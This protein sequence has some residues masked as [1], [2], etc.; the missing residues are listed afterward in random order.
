MNAFCPNKNNKQVM[1]EFNKLVDT[2]GEDLAYYYWNANGGY[3]LDRSRDGDLSR[4]YSEVMFATNGDE[5]AA[6][7]AAADEIDLLEQEGVTTEDIES[8]KLFGLNQEDIM[9]DSATI[10]AVTSMAEV[11]GVE[12]REVNF[13]RDDVLAAAN[14]LEKTIDITANAEDRVK[15]WNKLPEE[16]AH[17]WYRLLSY[18]TDLKHDLWEAA[19]KSEKYKQL[20]DEQYAD[21]QNDAAFVEEAIGQLIAEAMHNLENKNAKNFFDK[22][23]NKVKQII[24]KYI[25]HRNDPFYEAARRILN[26]DVSDLLDIT[27]V[28]PN[29]NNA[30]KPVV[31][32]VENVKFLK[33]VVNTLLKSKKKIEELTQTFKQY[34]NTNLKAHTVDASSIE[35]DKEVPA[36]LNS[37]NIILKKFRKNIPI[38]IV[39]T[40]QMIPGAKKLELRVY[41]RAIE[42]LR[43][44]SDKYAGKAFV[45]TEDFLTV[46]NHV[47]ENDYLLSFKDVLQRWWY[48]GMAETFV[49]WDQ[50]FTRNR[51]I[52]I[53]LN[54]TGIEGET[55]SGLQPHVTTQGPYAFGSIVYFKDKD[56]NT[57]AL[58]HEIQSDHV[59]LFKQMMN[60]VFPDPVRMKILDDNRASQEI[61]QAIASAL[62]IAS[63][64]DETGELVWSKTTVK[65]FKESLKTFVESYQQGV[66]DSK[67]L[68]DVKTTISRLKFK[69]QHYS[70]LAHAYKTIDAIFEANG[71]NQRF[72]DDLIEEGATRTWIPQVG[73][74][75]ITDKNG[76]PLSIKQFRSRLAFKR[77]KIMRKIDQ[78]DIADAERKLLRSYKNRSMLEYSKN[79]LKLSDSQLQTVINLI[80]QLEEAKYDYVQ[81][82]G[83]VE[84][85]PNLE[86][87]QDYF[88]PL[89]HHLIQTIIAEHG[90]D[91]K[92]FF[93]GYAMT[94]NL[95]RNAKTAKIYAN[96]V[97]VQRGLT[98]KIGLMYGAIKNLKG[99]KIQHVDGIEGMKPYIDNDGVAHQMDGLLLDLSNYEYDTPM[100]YSMKPKQDQQ[101]NVMDSPEIQDEMA[102]SIE[103]EFEMDVNSYPQEQDAFVV[104]KLKQAK[105]QDPDCDVTAVVQN[106]KHQFAEMKQKQ[107]MTDTAQRLAKIYG[108]ERTVDENGNVRYIS[109]RKDKDGK[110]DLVVEFLNYI[111]DDAAGF[112]DLNSKSTA[113][114]HVIGISLNNGD[115]ST[116][117]HELAHH[118]VRMFW[119]SKVIQMALRAVDKPGMTDEEREE[120]LVDF[121][122]AKTEDSQFESSLESQSIWQKF[123]SQFSYM[124]A[125]NF[126]IVNN[127]ARKQLLSNAA[128]AFM[129]NEQQQVMEAENRLFYMADQRMYKSSRQQKISRARKLSR[130]KS[131]NIDYHI[132]GTDATHVAI[133]KIIRGSVSRNKSYRRSEAEQP[134]ILVEMQLAEDE[135]R[136]YVD[137]VNKYREQ[138]AKSLNKTVDKLSRDERDQLVANQDEIDANVK[139]IRNFIKRARTE[140]LDLVNKLQSI[141]SNHYM[142]YLR[143]EEID[144]QTNQTVFNYWTEDHKGEPG[145]EEVPL[146]F[147]EIAQIME[148]IIG[149][150]F[151]TIKQLASAVSSVQFKYIYGQDIYEEFAK[152]FMSLQ[153]GERIGIRSIV[154]DIKTVMGDIIQNRLRMKIQE[155]VQQRTDL[156]LMQ[157]QR[158][159]Y[160]MN[161]WLEDQNI[162]GDCAWYE[163]L[164]GM[165]SNSKSPIIRF[166]QDV[167]D[168]MHDKIHEDVTKKGDE[169]VKLRNKAMKALRISKLS[170]FNFEKIVMERDDDGFTGNFSSRVNRG[171][172]NSRKDKFV[173]ELLFSGKNN[174]ED[175]VR[176]AIG[177]PDYEL[178]FDENGEVVFPDVCE[179]IRKEYLHK[180]NKWVGKNAIRE[181]TTEYYDA[182]IDIISQKTSNALR[183][184]DQRIN[185]LVEAAK[186]DGN[187]RGD[188]F[189]T[190]KREELQRLYEEKAQLANPYDRYGRKKTGDDLQ[191]AEEL[192]EWHAFTSDK[193][194]YTLNEEAFNESKLYSSDEQ[195]F[196]KEN[197]YKEINPEIWDEVSRIYPRTSSQKLKKLLDERRRL[198]SR[199]KNRGYTRPNIDI[200]WDKNTKDIRPEFKEFWENL[201]R[202]DR[203]ISIL[204]AKEN[205]GL[206]KN[207]IIA[208]KHKY[209]KILASVDITT[210]YNGKKEKWVTLISDQ[211]KERLTAQ[212]PTDPDLR[213]KI[214]QEIFDLLYYKNEVTG[215]LEY[216]SIF[217][218]SA[219]ILS[220]P[221]SRKVKIGNREVDAF[222]NTPMQA[223]S[224]IDVLNSD[225]RYVDQRFDR[226]SGHFVQPITIDTKNQITGEPYKI[227]QGDPDY[228][229]YTFIEKIDEVDDKNSKH[230]DEKLIPLKEYYTALYNTMKDAYEA[231]PFTG[232]YDGRLAQR[233]GSSQQM[234]YRDVMR[235]QYFKT[236]DWE[237]TQKNAFVRAI[238]SGID[239]MLTPLREWK[240]FQPL[241][242]V[243][244]AVSYHFA[245]KWGLP[246]ESDE[247]INMDFETRP[248]G[249]RS[250]NIPIRYI[251][252]LDNPRMISSDILG[253]VMKFYQMSVNYTEKANHLPLFNTFLEKFKSNESHNERQ[254]N[255]L[256][257]MISRQFY[258]RTKTMDFDP[259]NPRV[260]VS[261]IGKWMLKIIPGLRALTQTGLLALG[262]VAGIVSYLDPL[263]QSWIDAFSGKYI[264]IDD[265]VAG[266]IKML[267]D[268]PNAI[269]SIGSSKAYGFVPAGMRYMGLHRTG[270]SNFDK[271]NRSQISRVFNLNLLMSPFSLGE[272]TVD[273]KAFAST[274]HS[275]R[276]YNGKFYTKRQFIEEMENTG[277]MTGFKAKQYFDTVMQKHTLF[278]AYEISKDSDN[279]GEFVRADNEYG[280]AVDDKLESIVKKRMRNRATNYNYIVPG[281]ERTALQSHILASFLVVM[282]TFMLVGYQ[283]RWKSGHDFQLDNDDLINEAEQKERSREISIEN[284]A[285]KGMYNFQTGEIENAIHGGFFA[286]V[287]HPSRWMRYLKY[288]FFNIRNMGFVHS[289]YERKF[290]DKR[291]QLNISDEDLFGFNRTLTEILVVGILSTL[292]I[293]FH[294][295]LDDD[296]KN[297]YWLMLLDLI[298][299]RIAIERMTFLNFDTPV[300]LINSITPSKTDFD[301]KFKL[302]DLLQDFHAA[303]TQHKWDVDNWEKVK[304]GAYDK[305]PKVLKDL[306]QTLSSLGFHN[307]YTSSSIGGL[308]D[309]W[310][311]YQNLAPWSK[312]YNKKERKKSSKKQKDEFGN[313]WNFDTAGSEKWNW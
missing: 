282:R 259:L 269:R 311:W 172:Y 46:V 177:D 179:D 312:Y 293:I 297:N 215:K 294:N 114:H 192:S 182:R 127:T 68:N 254:K 153:M 284:Y 39:F 138:F 128:K 267:R 70:Y 264:N 188:L 251:K 142:Y 216:L 19:K 10:N 1:L 52:G 202:L 93:P 255:V 58:I 227:Q 87:M 12:I 4:T 260:T 272:Y 109:N 164:L 252:R 31:L 137:K 162:F 72:I 160:S 277:Q 49:N 199:I 18:S 274:M 304:G 85:T 145:V 213:R 32:D 125:R 112:Y 231:I 257:G 113:A 209:S 270:A 190:P 291:E 82:D 292:S 124:L 41:N 78:Q 14:F 286:I 201:K 53:W 69:L 176:A 107:L 121:M 83:N 186:R 308:L 60:Q 207:E 120:A 163:T 62:Y 155:E 194:A 246:N 106:A 226:N 84:N 289:R 221:V 157:Q 147:K 88:N 174:Y 51:K 100:L 77:S 228:T 170:P 36:G 232:N 169:L 116:F 34:K 115:P 210:S 191:I 296:D 61:P 6:M 26:T 154:D 301:R 218:T 156:S 104:E 281:G 99:I 220:D 224:I 56:G 103:E 13:G 90:K 249:S 263:I 211:I 222:V 2:F 89:V 152:E 158:L 203:E 47:L 204:R 240:M 96:D 79:L 180:L 159:V 299:M 21:Y 75:H 91:I 81:K 101:V 119:K 105:E 48:Y 276:Y 3:F 241:R 283:E 139:L 143:S 55:K 80:K 17:W 167:I 200:I 302:F 146:D 38:D 245:R 35:F 288:M 20:S 66:L 7:R 242:A 214:D 313:D 196:I 151:G 262:F 111:E 59:E 230:Y 16:V 64:P 161:T 198:I 193:V 280:R 185:A 67:Q 130:Q 212:N 165:P 306:F 244:H 173:D 25:T 108:L 253:S 233:A 309:K 135:V 223:Y 110:A 126:N 307:A 30:D 271:M 50:S 248:D 250:L 71:I 275:F 131:K 11:L 134:K 45:Q 122:T 236:G 187:F 40:S 76:N 57:C 9:F 195:K 268:L 148:N 258:D 22:M 300:E 229:N 8:A 285:Y 171:K 24:S 239:F 43:N 54:R 117:S 298:L 86:F 243:R 65:S 237:W 144:P 234:L 141:Q 92:I 95:Q 181:F 205:V 290:K 305:K 98:D 166:L 279:K 33:R 63:R 15:A 235:G 42:L 136:E 149:F 133:D 197:T 225:P 27:Q 29:I 44:D 94:M 238:S 150:Y 261:D 129:I 97:D 208:R 168:D 273:A 278:D 219:P 189:S 132:I 266:D 303:Y 206:T 118:Y 310:K 184:Y 217:E 287:F 178:E 37:I 183:E 5:K 123:W 175:Q 256:A 23:W 295:S 28:I 102:N 265:Y 74:V 140:L 73:N 247:D